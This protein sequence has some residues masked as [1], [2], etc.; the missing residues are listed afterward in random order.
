M[1]P[2]RGTCFVSNTFRCLPVTVTAAYD[3]STKDNGGLK[4]AYLGRRNYMHV[5]AETATHA[6]A[7]TLVEAFGSM[8]TDA[9]FGAF[10]PDA[11]FIFHTE[12]QRVSGTA[13][14]RRLW[15]DWMAGG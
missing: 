2:Q 5:A 1:V 6:A 3:M 11:T 7:T 15:A 13:D 14:Y 4:A 10:G 12:P 8:N 9:Y